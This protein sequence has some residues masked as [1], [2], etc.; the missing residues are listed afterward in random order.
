[1]FR[2]HC[3][4]K[5]R[6]G[7]RN[8][9]QL[10]FYDV[11]RDCNIRYHCASMLNSPSPVL[12]SRF[13]V[14]SSIAHTIVS[15][16]GPCT[17]IYHIMQRALFNPQD[18]TRVVLGALILWFGWY[19]FN[20]GSALTMESPDV[21]SRTAITTTLSAASGAM[22]SLVIS[23]ITSA[24]LRTMRE[25]F[26]EWWDGVWSN[27]ISSALISDEVYRFSV[28]AAA[29]GVLAGLVGITAGCSVVQVRKAV[30]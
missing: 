10:D 22:S 27:D 24:N 7:G 2:F 15:C 13:L 21:V 26:D 30:F 17:D 9:S 14:V 11:R 8:I 28:L 6:T 20:P 5:S 23:L 29:N 18:E 25:D 12:C 19:G 4:V 3:C 1:M 16:D